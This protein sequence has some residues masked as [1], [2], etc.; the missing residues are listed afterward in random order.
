VSYLTD[1]SDTELEAKIAAALER[2]HAPN[3]PH[4]N[5]F[6]LHADG[7]KEIRNPSDHWAR[8]SRDWI[9]LCDERDRRRLIT[10]GK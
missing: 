6:N 3:P 4:I 5:E 9:A 7:T 2:A 8:A 1:L 10:A